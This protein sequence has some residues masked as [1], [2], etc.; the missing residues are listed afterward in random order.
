M[1]GVFGIRHTTANPHNHN[2][3]SKL[4]GKFPAEKFADSKIICTFAAESNI[5]SMKSTKEYI[6]LISAHADELRVL[7][8]IRSMRISAEISRSWGINMSAAAQ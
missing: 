6:D 2:P 3:V 5:C 4:P 8:G 7:F 1:S